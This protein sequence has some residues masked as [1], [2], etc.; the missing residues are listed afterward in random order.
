MVQLILN[1]MAVKLGVHI[2]AVDRGLQ[3]V[4]LRLCAVSCVFEIV[5]KAKICDQNV[6]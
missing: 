1:G 5:W 6:N 2:I 3:T 4:L